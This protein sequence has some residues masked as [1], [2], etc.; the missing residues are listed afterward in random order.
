MMV[1]SMSRVLLIAETDPD[2]RDAYSLLCSHRGLMAETAT[3]GLECLGKFSASTPDALLVDLEILWGGG[4]GVLACAQDGSFGARDIAIF[5][6]GCDSPE[7]LSR[8][9][10]IPEENCFQKP[11]RVGTVLDSICSV[12]ADNASSQRRSRSS[13]PRV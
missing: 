9:S 8:R 1:V 7:L 12:L 2:L 4:D 13:A 5:V 11:F 10:G 3:D 6:T